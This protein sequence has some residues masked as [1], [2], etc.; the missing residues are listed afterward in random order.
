MALTSA[1][2]GRSFPATR[3]YAV[4]AEKVAEFVTATAGAEAGANYNGATVP[5]TFP[6]LLSFDAMFAFLAAE[7]IELSRIIHGDQKFRYER[8]LRPGDVLAATLTVTS[9]RHINGTDI[10]GTT[11]EI[12]DADGELVCTTSATLL[13]RGPG[14]E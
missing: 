8:P 6:I 3:L 11:S 7:R 5:A 2:V 14:D 12:T 4:S 10:I 13:H 1:V 9:L